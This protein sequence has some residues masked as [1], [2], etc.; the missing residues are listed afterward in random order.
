MAYPSEFTALMLI[1]EV[2]GLRIQQAKIKACLTVVQLGGYG[3]LMVL[4]LLPLNPVGAG[5]LLRGSC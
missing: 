3:F 2:E 1:R 5:D 4:F